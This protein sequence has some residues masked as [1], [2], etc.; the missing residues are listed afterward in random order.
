MTKQFHQLKW[1]AS[2][3]SIISISITQRY[4]SLSP[5]HPSCHTFQMPISNACKYSQDPHNTILDVSSDVF[6]NTLH[7]AYICVSAMDGVMNERKW[8][9]LRRWEHSNSWSPRPDAVRRGKTAWQMQGRGN[10]KQ[11][12]RSGADQK[13]MRKTLSIYS[14]YQEKKLYIHEEGV[15]KKERVQEGYRQQEQCES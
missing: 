10:A 7:W 4:Q 15:S 13:K 6:V 1:G 14:N 9:L 5:R 2:C 8:P 3:D 12:C 11:E